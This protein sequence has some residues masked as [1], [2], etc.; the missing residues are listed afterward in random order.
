MS[1]RLSPH[2]LAE[3]KA[4]TLNNIE[5]GAYQDVHVSVFTPLRFAE[6]MKTLVELDLIQYR[7]KAFIDT[8]LG[9]ME[10]FVR[11]QQCDHKENAV[12]SWK[13]T[14]RKLKSRLTQAKF[15]LP[16]LG[17]LV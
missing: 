11:L 4:N 7:C 9:G 16:R 17:A 2:S 15:A 8:K 3:I 6:L 5:S 12:D 1:A 14:C 10:F 13:A